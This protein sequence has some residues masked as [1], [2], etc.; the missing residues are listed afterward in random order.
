V[1]SMNRNLAG[2]A[3]KVLSILMVVFLH[4]GNGLPSHFSASS[5]GADDLALLFMHWVSNGVTRVAVPIFF[6]LSGYFMMLKIMKSGS[7]S[8][9]SLL[10]DRARTVLIPY[11]LW[12]LCVF[13][14]FAL[15]QI[16]EFTHRY[17]N[18]SIIWDMSW[19][20]V[21]KTVFVEPIPYQ[22]W[23]LRDLFVIFVAL[24]VLL[25][26]LERCRMLFFPVLLGLWCSDFNFGIATEGILFFSIGLYGAGRL[27]RIATPGELSVLLSLWFA[28]AIL[29]VFLRLSDV[30][31]GLLAYKVQILIG[32]FTLV[33]MA[34]A[35]WFDW[36]ARYAAYAFPVFLFHE[37]ALMLLKKVA[38]AVTTRS[39]VTD[40]LLFLG[41][42]VIVILFSI[43]AARI[44]I[45]FGGWFYVFLVGGRIRHVPEIRA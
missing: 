39:A 18:R 8:Y 41:M 44:A 1:T 5:G 7:F 29:A 23:F 10:Q 4:S 21:A 2:D 14:L 30:Y 33:Q 9:R 35:G 42:P 27:P 43:V 45:K 6:M 37:P 15:I 13:V 32:V 34:R 22:L 24:P 25:K 26:L 3:L 28:M 38:F 20:E 16:P 40:S 12:S 36:L 31:G 19:Y 17:F 11:L